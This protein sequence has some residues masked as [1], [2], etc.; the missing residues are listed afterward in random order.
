MFVLKGM[1]QCSYHKQPK[2]TIYQE[3]TKSSLRAGYLEEKGQELNN[4][5]NSSYQV[6]FHGI[7]ERSSY[8]QGFQKQLSIFVWISDGKYKNLTK[9][10]APYKLA[11]TQTFG[12]KKIVIGNCNFK[13]T[14]NEQRKFQ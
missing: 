10:I 11:T 1:Q 14:C 12:L 3:C 6:C 5:E 13:I 7:W 4:E 8:Y 2:R 9:K